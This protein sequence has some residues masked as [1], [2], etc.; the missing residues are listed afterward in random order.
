M[1][2]VLLAALLSLPTPQ[3]RPLVDY[4]IGPQDVLTITV[5]GQ[6]AHSGDVVVKP[7]G[8]ISLSLIGEVEAAGSTPVQLKNV[9]TKLYARYFKEP[10]ILVAVKQING[11]R[12]FI[13]GL[14]AKPG[15][16]RFERPMDLL[17]LLARAGGLLPQADRENI[18]LL[19]KHRD[20]KVEEIVFNYRK[21]F[22]PK[23]TTEI[24]QLRPG[25]EVIVK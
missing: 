17:Q 25:D 13:S 12:V 1:I 18:R 3:V 11:E 21:L 10:T 24:P 6:D 23:G 15:D 22:E 8:T 16:Y 4:V 7:D 14:V 5:F 9:L 19:R 20:G 2:A